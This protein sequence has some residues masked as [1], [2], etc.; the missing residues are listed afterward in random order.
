[1][2]FLF[3]FH[4]LVDAWRKSDLCV[5]VVLRVPQVGKPWLKPCWAIVVVHYPGA[6][7]FWIHILRKNVRNLCL[8]HFSWFSET[9]GVILQKCPWKHI[10]RMYGYYTKQGYL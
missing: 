10:Y 6:C 3:T 1:M 9:N 2:R 5:P 8:H 7:I 4:Q